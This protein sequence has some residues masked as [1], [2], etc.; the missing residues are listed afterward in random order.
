[1]TPWHN[2]NSRNFRC[3]GCVTRS[4]TQVRK[5]LAVS[6]KEKACWTSIV[7]LRL[8]T[9]FLCTHL[10]WSGLSLS[11]C[12]KQMCKYIYITIY[13][14][15]NIIIWLS[16][17]IVYVLYLWDLDWFL[18]LNLTRILAALSPC[19]LARTL[20]VGLFR[21][22]KDYFTSSDPQP[23]TLFWHSFC[24]IIWKYIWRIMWVNNNKPPI[25]E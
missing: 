2:W 5:V 14:Y 6:E 25:W 22:W 1:M 15:N 7:V 4:Y 23:D 10:K 24:N 17:Y 19:D 16:M 3:C 21:P 18:I 13:I 8:E 20:E 11:L 9:K 12:I